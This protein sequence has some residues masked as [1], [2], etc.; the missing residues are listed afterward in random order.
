MADLSKAF[1]GLSSDT[2]VVIEALLQLIYRAGEFQDE[3]YD[4][5]DA[6]RKAR[7]DAAMDAWRWW[8]GGPDSDELYEDEFASEMEALAAGDL[9]YA[10]EGKFRIVE[11]RGWA[12]SVEDGAD[13]IGF[14][15]T[16][17]AS[18]VEVKAHD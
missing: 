6:W 17:N 14:A 3:H 7:G 18:V 4:M 11:A 8:I 15:A 5:L 10:A 13:E 16:R 9:R 12:D 2:N 1:T